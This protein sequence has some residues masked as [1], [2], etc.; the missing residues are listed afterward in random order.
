ME[1][2]EKKGQSRVGR[3]LF[4]MVMG[5]LII[6]G[7]IFVPR[8]TSLIIL[9]ILLVISLIL[10]IFLRRFKIPFINYFIDRLEKKGDEKKFPGKGFI[11]LLA[12]SLLVAKLF[13]MDIAL[14]SIAILTFGDATANLTRKAIP[15]KKRGIFKNMT[16]TL[17]G[18]IVS[19]FAALLFIIP[20][21]AIIAAAIA[22]FVESL[23]IK[24]GESEADDNII[25]PLVAGTVIYILKFII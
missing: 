2:K 16:G 10:A 18:I 6:L 5:I 21:Y 3:Q 1:K 15:I 8:P 23:A 14:A 17:V 9:F 22:M 11:F 13:P 25:I 24:L 20:L 4:H 12:G 19:F 7:L